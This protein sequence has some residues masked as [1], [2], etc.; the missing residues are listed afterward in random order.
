MPLCQG[1]SR[2]Q[3]EG[4]PGSSRQDQAGR[5]L[6]G[7]CPQPPGRLS[8]VGLGGGAEARSSGRPAGADRLLPLPTCSFSG[9]SGPGPG[10][11]VPAG[12][13]LQGRSPP[14]AMRRVPVPQKPWDPT[15]GKKARAP[16][17]LFSS[18]STQHGGRRASRPSV[19]PAQVPCGQIGG[20]QAC[21]YG[22][23]CGPG[24]RGLG[25]SWPGHCPGSSGDA[26]A[27]VHPDRRRRPSWEIGSL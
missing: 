19:W 17:G 16:Q 24:L 1:T 10:S 23:G 5:R 11:A 20:R 15:E 26:R 8:G 7:H 21:S 22:R 2:N 9:H 18:K 27:R 14:W 25:T 12:E 4:E 3:Q 6:P 13:S